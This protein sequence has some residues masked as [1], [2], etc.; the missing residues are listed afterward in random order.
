[1]N[2]RSYK[3]NTKPIQACPSFIICFIAKICKIR[4]HK[5]HE[6][7]PS[8]TNICQNNQNIKEFYSNIYFL[9]SVTHAIIN[10]SIFAQVR[11][12]IYYLFSTHL[13]PFTLQYSYLLQSCLLFQ[14]EYHTLQ[15]Q[16]SVLRHKSSP[17]LLFLSTF[18]PQ[19][20]QLF[21]FSEQF[22]FFSCQ[23]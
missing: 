8:G 23:L 3:S 22:S 15:V 9:S 5:P 13:L 16:T 12:V 19:V 20:F 6:N 7:N 11:R 4:I 10:T 17:L 18:L 2:H 14:P 1:M 21:S